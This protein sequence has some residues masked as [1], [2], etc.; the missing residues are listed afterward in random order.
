[1]NNQV[2]I[3]KK[4]KSFKNSI[5]VSS[6]KSLS[7]RCILLSSMA[8]G[9]SRIYNYLNSE[10]VINTLKSV[11][12]IGVSYKKTQKYIEIDGLGINGFKIG[13]NTVLNAGNSGTL[14]RCILGFCSGINK[15]IKLIKFFLRMTKI[16]R[17]W[18]IIKLTVIGNIFPGNEL[19]YGKTIW[20]NGLKDKW[21]NTIKH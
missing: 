9:K 11:K 1:M 2:K 19:E 21:F 20:I 15:K 10:D 5:Y 4:I 3:V 7:I 6:D 14:A 16:I 8:I 17:N 13:E 12:K 18:M